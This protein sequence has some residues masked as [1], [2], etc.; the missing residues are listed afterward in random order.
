MKCFVY[1]YKAS[2]AMPAQ[3]NDW[4]E[5]SPWSCTYWL[6]SN[7][8]IFC[9][10]L[11]S[12]FRGFTLKYKRILCAGNISYLDSCSVKHSSRVWPLEDMSSL[13]ASYKS[14]SSRDLH[15]TGGWE[16]ALKFHAPPMS[17]EAARTKWSPLYFF[18]QMWTAEWGSCCFP[19][20]LKSQ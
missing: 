19:F 9:H 5:Q 4:S 12:L 13:G 3:L 1:S 7:S 15:Q 20:L 18:L 11:G 14:S 17:A 8:L 10:L 2:T 6:V 16:Q